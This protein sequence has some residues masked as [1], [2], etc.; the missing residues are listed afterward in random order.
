[1]EIR[2]LFS[3]KNPK[4]KGRNTREPYPC[5]P[6]GFLKYNRDKRTGHLYITEIG[7]EFKSIDKLLKE[8]GK[9]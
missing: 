1:M 9:W 7:N 2:L 5:V 6:F 3:L 4:T 8:V